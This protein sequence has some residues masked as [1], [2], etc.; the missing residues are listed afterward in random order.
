MEPADCH[1][2]LSSSA[3]EDTDGDLQSMT[4]T[5]LA[6]FFFPKLRNLLNPFGVSFGDRA[7]PETLPPALPGVLVFSVLLSARFFRRRAVSAS[8]AL[9][10]D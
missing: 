4:V 5:S 6:L 1:P 8:S 3:T 10:M 2:P 9:S 7:A